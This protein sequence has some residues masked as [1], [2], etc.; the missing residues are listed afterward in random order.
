MVP[1]FQKSDWMLSQQS[2]QDHQAWPSSLL[3]VPA[4]VMQGG[5]VTRV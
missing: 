3:W 5:N 2:F 4:S 1:P